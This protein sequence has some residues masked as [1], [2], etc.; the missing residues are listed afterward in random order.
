[1][2]AP[3]DSSSPLASPLSSACVLVHAPFGKDG[4][5]IT[6]V[7]ERAGIEARCCATLEQLYPAVDECPGAILV[8]EEALTKRSVE[9]FA[10][11]LNGQPPWSDL[12]V[13]VMTTGGEPDE[14]SL[15]RLQLMTPLG[16]VSLIERPFRKITLL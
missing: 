9:K 2:I 3:E 8:A 14:T 15:Y 7:L 16:N 5:V 11:W 12:P 10:S 6:R 1:M 13:I 4:E